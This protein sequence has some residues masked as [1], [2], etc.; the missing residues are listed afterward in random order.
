MLLEFRSLGVARRM[1]PGS[2]LAG[3]YAAVSF[4]RNID[5]MVLF[6]SV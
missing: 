5:A 4:D 2:S 3:R 6:L 1:C